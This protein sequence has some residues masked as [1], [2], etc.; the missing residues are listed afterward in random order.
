M[1]ECEFLIWRAFTWSLLSLSCLISSTSRWSL[2]SFTFLH[3]TMP[4]FSFLSHCLLFLL[5]A[6]LHPLACGLLTIFD[7][8]SCILLLPSSSSSNLDH[9]P[10][11][12][13]QFSLVLHPCNFHSVLSFILPVPSF[14]MS[15]LL[16]S[17]SS[18]LFSPLFTPHLSSS[19]LG[20][21]L[22][23]FSLHHPV[24]TLQSLWNLQIFYPHPSYAP[25]LLFTSFFPSSHHQPAPLLIHI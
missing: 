16:T 25:F 1:F 11:V 14:L 5:I 7:S 2:F 8:S 3:L 17:L 6:P 21:S 4:S 22:G 10:L 20:A 13:G 18:S 23:Y 19:P 12:L 24:L 15:H 9:L